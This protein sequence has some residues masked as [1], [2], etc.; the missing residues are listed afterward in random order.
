MKIPLPTTRRKARIEIIPLIDVIFFLLATFVMVSLSMVKNQ[1]IRVNLPSAATGA[2]QER[3]AAATI[4]VTKVGDIY[5]NQEK[6][7]SDL[8]PQR[9]K[10][11]KA[12][13]PDM[14]VFINGDKEAYFGNAIQ[15]LDVVRS[16]GI[17]KVAI[18][19]TQAEPL[20]K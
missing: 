3:E 8:L 11:L 16:S 1:G 10:Q 14:R 9:L 19:T 5:L 13:N 2:P 17:T 15:I 20:Q 18:Q 4:T 12:E 7:A 6:L